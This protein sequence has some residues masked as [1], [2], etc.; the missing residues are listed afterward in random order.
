MITHSATDIMASYDP[1]RFLSIQVTTELP[2]TSPHPIFTKLHSIMT[3]PTP[4]MAFAAMQFSAPECRPLK[5]EKRKGRPKE[6]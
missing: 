1:H 6:S 5:S 4:I 3:Q 2:K